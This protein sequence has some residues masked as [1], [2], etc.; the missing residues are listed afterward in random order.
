MICKDFFELRGDRRYADD[1]AILGG[2]TTIANQT[3]MLIGHQKGR[4]SNQKLACNFGMP[5][6][7]GYRKAQRLMRLA[8]KFSFPVICLIDTPGAYPDLESEQRGQ[9]Q[10]IAESLEIMATLCVPL[11]AIVIGEGGSGGALALGLADRILMLEH[12]IYTVAAP[13]AAA[14]ILWRDNALPTTY[15]MR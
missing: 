6:P 5:R 4:D 7:E 13:E 8:E 12:A 15:A 11:V 14:S 9:A 1:Q 2:L 3:V 10:A